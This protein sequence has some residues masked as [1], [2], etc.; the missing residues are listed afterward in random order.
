MVFQGI[1]E[2]GDATTYQF[3]RLNMTASQFAHGTDPASPQ[4]LNPFLT[5]SGL[6]WSY[7]VASPLATVT[8]VSD[9]QVRTSLLIAGVIAVLAILIGLI[10]G[11]GT[12][13]PVRASVM[14]LEGAAAALKALA[15][16]QQASA[17]EQH[18]VVDACKTGLEG[19]RYLSDATNQA[20]RRIIDASNWFSEYWDR[21]T[22]DQARRTVQHLQELAH[23]IDEA[24]RRQQASSDR[25]DKAITVTMQVSDQLVAGATAATESASQLE[26]VVGDLQHVVGGRRANHAAEVAAGEAL[27]PFAQGRQ[28][29]PPAALPRQ[30]PAPAPPPRQ[31]RAGQGAQG[32]WPSTADPGRSQVGWGEVPQA[33]YGPYYDPN[34][35][36]EQQGNGYSGYDANGNAYNGNGYDA[37]QNGNPWGNAGRMPPDGRSRGS[38]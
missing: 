33:P 28:E 26:Q 27:D 25:L 36:G 34:G 31:V 13:R 1:A 24:A 37:G 38:W 5:Q 15:A 12:T 14:E 4:S 29:L 30:I 9:Q 22:E 32:G 6:H 23:Y 18:W 11:R 20:A 8:A 10:V 19:V 7:F 2:P 21:L 35:Y 3:V 17:G 16:R